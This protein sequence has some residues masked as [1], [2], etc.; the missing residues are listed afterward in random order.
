MADTQSAAN[1]FIDMNNPILTKLGLVTFSDSSRIDV[2][3][4]NNYATVKAGVNAI[5]PGGT[6]NASAGLNSALTELQSTNARV[7]ASKFIV[8]LTDG[9]PNNGCSAC[10]T[11]GCCPAAVNAAYNAANTAASRAVTIFTIGLGSMVD[12][13]MLQG[14]ADRTGGDYFHAPTSADLQAIYE[15]VFEKIKV[16]LVQ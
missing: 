15:T 10:T 16:R 12:G 2:H 5:N 4:T 1:R 8:F 9:V 11:P 7:D 3:L 6:T 13:V 14:I